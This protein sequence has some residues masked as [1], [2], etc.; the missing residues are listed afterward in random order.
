MAEIEKYKEELKNKVINSLINYV[1]EGIL[2]N[3]NQSCF[4][5]CYTIIQKLSNRDNNTEELFKFHNEVIEQITTE[6][7]EKIK[8]I[9]GIEF[10]DYFILCTDRLSYFIL[11]MSNIFSYVSMFY[12]PFHE[13][14]NELSEFS[15]DI[16][17]KFFFNKLQNKL[18]TLFK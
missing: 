11:Y 13:G 8:D 6:C 9:N 12:L 14:K 3:I 4:L 16:Y 10:I 17:K 2:P 5:E 15:M 7:Y 18:F 1:R